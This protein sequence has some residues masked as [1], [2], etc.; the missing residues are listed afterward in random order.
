MSSS[1]RIKDSLLRIV[2][3]VLRPTDYH[4]MYPARVVS[5]TSEGLLE[6]QP[7]DA[8]LKGMGNIPIR[9]GIPCVNAR[10]RKGSRVM[11]EFENG[12]PNA[13]VATVWDTASVEKLV[14]APDKLFIGT[15]GG[16][17]WPIARM[18]DM[19]ECYLTVPEVAKAVLVPNPTGV[20]KLPGMITSGATK[21][22]SA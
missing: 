8:R 7:E 17:A 16:D 6:V 2:S 4:A 3:H 22:H 13:P 19:V 21:G 14:V 1:D 15:D 11:I 9:Y 5:Q 10:I 20:I 18:G 12:N